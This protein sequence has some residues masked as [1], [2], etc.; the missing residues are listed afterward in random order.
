MHWQ[1]QEVMVTGDDTDDVSL[2]TDLLLN[3]SGPD[4]MGGQMRSQA[5]EYVSGTSHEQMPATAAGEKVC[6]TIAA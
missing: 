2:L 1:Q 3:D 5:S 6:D 4:V